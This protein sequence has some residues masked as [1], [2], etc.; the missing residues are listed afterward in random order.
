M[1]TNHVIASLNKA[2]KAITVAQVTVRQAMAKS[3][4]LDDLLDLNVTDDSLMSV[5]EVLLAN[6]GLVERLQQNDTVALLERCLAMNNPK[7]P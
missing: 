3:A 6:L 4:N 1:D 2:L 5:R 7:S